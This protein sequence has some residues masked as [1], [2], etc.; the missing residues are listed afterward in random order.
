MRICGIDPGYALIGYAIID[1]EGNRLLP[2]NYSKIETS[3]KLTFF[4]RMKQINQEFKAMLNKYNPEYLAIEKLY[5]SKNS[6]TALDVAQIRG[7]MLQEAL[8]YNLDI[9]EY[10]PTEV[11]L[12]VTGYG[13]AD[14]QQIQ[15]MVKTLLNLDKIPKPDDIADA[16]AI[17]IC[18]HNCFKIK[19]L[20]RKLQYV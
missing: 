18:H 13:K 11:K 6:K 15:H 16:L 7:A 3:S 17:A 19:N 12:A 20:E 14:K 10:S 5:F 1:I 4:E 2:V 8:N 9:Y